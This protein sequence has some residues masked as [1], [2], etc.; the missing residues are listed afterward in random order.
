[1]YVGDKTAVSGHMQ[2]DIEGRKDIDLTRYPELMHIIS[3][4][5]PG[6]AADEHITAFVNNVG[7]GFQFTVIAKVI[8]EAA[9]QKG[10]GKILPNEW[11]SQ[12]VHS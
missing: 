12:S 2:R 5:E 1:M 10:I 8:L 4:R 11:F 3:G 7:I 9:R 6:R